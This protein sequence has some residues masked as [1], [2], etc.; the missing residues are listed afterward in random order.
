MFPNALHEDPA[1]NGGP[2][3]I[4][5]PFFQFNFDMQEPAGVDLVKCLVADRDVTADLPLVLRDMEFTP[6]P[7]D[8][9]FRLHEIFRDIRN[10]S[11]TEAS[12]VITVRP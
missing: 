6:L 10:A 9:R 8:M 4:P 2:H 7:G 12:L 5:G 11:I 3:Q 1:I